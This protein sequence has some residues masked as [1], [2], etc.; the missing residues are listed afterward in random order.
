MVFAGFCSHMSP[1]D[2]SVRIALGNILGP[3]LV[4]AL[5]Q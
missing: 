1:P 2:N 5:K 4:F 3:M